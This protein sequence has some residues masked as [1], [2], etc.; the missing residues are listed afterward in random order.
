MEDVAL[1]G[2]G[3]TSPTSRRLRSVF[4]KKTEYIH[5][6]FDVGRLM[7]EVHQFHSRL[8]RFI[9]MPT[10]ELK[11]DTEFSP[12]VN[13]NITD[14]KKNYGKTITVLFNNIVFGICK[15][16]IVS[17]PYFIFRAASFSM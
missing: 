14:H 2:A 16:I 15:V 9:F 17:K 1:R 10:V 4:F 12:Y 8:N 3:A 7:F 13:K 6:T 5:S 11:H